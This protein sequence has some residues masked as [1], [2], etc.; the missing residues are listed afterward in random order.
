MPNNAFFTNLDG[1]D[2]QAF[3]LE[4]TSGMHCLI[5]N[6]GARLL[7]I[8]APDRSG[9]LAD[10]LLGHDDIDGYLKHPDT[11]FGVTVGRVANR[12]AG[13]AFTL[14]GKHYSL[15]A[16]DGLNH[17]HGGSEGFHTKVWQVIALEKNRVVLQL[18][19][20][21]GEGGYPGHVQVTVTYTLE[22]DNTVR[23][24]YTATADLDTPLN[25][26]NHAY[27][28]LKGTGMGSIDD[29][30][31]QINAAQYLP[32]GTDFI[33]T[34]QVAQV[35]GSPF[36]FRKPAVLSQRLNKNHPQL[37]N[38]KGFDHHFIPDGTGFR[39]MARMW[40]PES[41]RVLEVWS[42][43]PGVQFYS[44]NFLDGSVTGKGGVPCTFRSGFCFEAQHY[45]NSLNEPAFPSIILKAGTTYASTCCYKFGVESG[46]T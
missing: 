14:G 30:V 17:L 25:L 46:T 19:S 4:N 10:V 20:P 35:E 13:A 28:K 22:D 15:E 7:Q 21:D 8:W 12:T 34:G 9:L 44:G 45:P 27:F 37:T 31:L 32:I 24:D 36:D 3:R 2:V 16:N 1:R 38:G 43:A 41:G 33:P 40:E 42:D 5:S 39:S 23:I 29:H 18:H 6:Y 11:F 26:T